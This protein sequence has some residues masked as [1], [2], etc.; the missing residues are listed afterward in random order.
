LV[1]GVEMVRKEYELYQ[2]FLIN[3]PTWWED[4]FN[5]GKYAENNGYYRDLLK[6]LVY[7]WFKYRRLNNYSEEVFSH[8]FEREIRNVFDRWLELTQAEALR[9]STETFQNIFVYNVHDYVGSTSN[10]NTANRT[11]TNTGTVQ[12]VGADNRTLNTQIE[13][14]YTGTSTTT[15]TGTQTNNE[16]KNLQ[17]Q[18]TYNTQVANTGT[19]T[20]EN[21]GTQTNANTHS[22]TNSNTSDSRS[23]ATNLPQSI[24]AGDGEFETHFDGVDGEPNPVHNTQAGWYTAGS[25]AETKGNGSGSSSG[26]A[27]DTRTDNLQ[28]ERTDNLTSSTTGTDTLARTGTD[29]TT[30]T[31]NLTEGLTRNL[32]DLSKNTGTDN[33]AKNNTRTNN[34]SEAITGTIKDDGTNQGLEKGRT[35]KNPYEIIQSSMDAIRSF[36]STDWLVEKLNSCFLLIWTMDDFDEDYEDE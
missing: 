15:N 31:D 17:D 12:D 11:I 9:E 28:S 35:N 27:S 7:A 4:T 26:T 30:R 36:C 18:T 34:L 14:D 16:T 13:T 29:N 2:K 33:L 22:D 1:K 3:N 24:T 19:Q 25:K 6:A 10:T 5:S 32:K 8:Y 20:T 23:L 21:T